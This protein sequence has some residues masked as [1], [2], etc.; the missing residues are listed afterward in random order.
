MIEL[1]LHP[2]RVYNMDETAFTT[3]SKSKELLRA[4]TYR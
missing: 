2:S 1:K 3:R 4:S